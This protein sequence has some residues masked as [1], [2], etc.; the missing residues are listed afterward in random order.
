MLLWTVSELM[1]LTRDELC[2]L[3]GNL[4][5]ALAEFEA[6]ACERSDVLTTLDNIRRVMVARGLHY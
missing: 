5:H 4:R 2:S 3:D 1:H 6:G